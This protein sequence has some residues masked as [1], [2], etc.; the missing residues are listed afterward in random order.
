MTDEADLVKDLEHD[1]LQD[2]LSVSQGLGK[3]GFVAA[4]IALR[5]C[6]AYLVNGL[7]EG[8][9]RRK[10]D[11]W[12]DFPRAYLSGQREPG[13]R[14]GGDDFSV[15]WNAAVSGYVFISEPGFLIVLVQ[16]LIRNLVHGPW[17]ETSEALFD[18]SQWIY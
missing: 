17:N 7:D 4:C 15:R 9:R 16:L 12:L 18:S 10:L 13:A 8:M 11:K 6:A 14:T 2:E 3:V 5:G 1:L